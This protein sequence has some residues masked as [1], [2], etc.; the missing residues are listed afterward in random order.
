MQP[1][2]GDLGSVGALKGTLGCS[3]RVGIWAQ[4]GLSKA[5]SDAV[6]VWG[7]GWRDPGASF[8][9]FGWLAPNEGW[10]R[11]QGFAG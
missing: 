10:F 8:W 5:P 7:F 6:Y 1:A 9:G 4:Q 3:L 2:C 11:H